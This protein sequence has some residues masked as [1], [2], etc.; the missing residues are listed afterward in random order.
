MSKS[1][2]HFD[3]V[4][5]FSVVV[6]FSFTSCSKIREKCHSHFTDHRNPEMIIEKISGELNLTENQKKD[7]KNIKE[8]IRFEKEKFKTS[9]KEIVTDFTQLLK[10]DNI[11]ENEL[12]NIFEKIENKLIQSRKVISKKM[13]VFLSSLTPEQKNK[14]ITK[15]NK[16]NL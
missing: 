12:D 8:V 4:I 5:I 16:S 14:I 11:D 13:A 10:K 6:L 2:F 1:I 3:L 9:K 15:I 7:F